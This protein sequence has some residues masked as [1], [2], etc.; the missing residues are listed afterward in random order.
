M[1]WFNCPDTKQATYPANCRRE[2]QK[3]S[4][5]KE[6]MKESHTGYYLP[7]QQPKRG[8]RRMTRD[9]NGI[10]V[11][12][13]EKLTAEEL[14]AIC[15]EEVANWKAQKRAISKIEITV[16]GDELVVHTREKSP[17]KRVRRIT[18]YLSELANFNEA[19]HAEAAA[20]EVHLNAGEW[21]MFPKDYE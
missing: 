13:P 2:C 16:E 17:I 14:V 11:T 12:F 3:T 21:P 1:N 6:Y 10:P 9:F 15:T 20:R 18:G 8:K 5:C 7:R 4:L 19:K